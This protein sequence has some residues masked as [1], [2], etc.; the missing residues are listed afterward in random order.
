M[1]FR[2]SARRGRF[3][4]PNIGDAGIQALQKQQSD[5]IKFLDL[6]RRQNLARGEKHIANLKGVANTESENARIIQNVENDIYKTKVD[7]IN[8]AG[9]RDVQ[10]LRDEAKMFEASSKFW[11]DFSGAGARALGTA[12]QGLYDMAEF[13]QGRR[14][15]ENARD[16][17]TLRQFASATE[18]LYKIEDGKIVI[19][20]NRKDITGEEGRYLGKQRRSTNRYYAHL[21]L[22]DFEDNKADYYR[23][24]SDAFDRFLDQQEEAGNPVSAKQLAPE[25]YEAWATHVLEQKGV[26]PSLKKSQEFIDDFVVQGTQVSGVY[27]R[28][29]LYTE[30]QNAVKDDLKVLL[31]SNDENRSDD[32]SSLISS[33][34]E[35]YTKDDK[36]RVT[37]FIGNTAD[38]GVYVFTEVLAKH[39]T[40]T[41]DKMNAILDTQVP[42]E[43]ITYREK[44]KNRNIEELV[45]EA[46]IDNQKTITQ[47]NKALDLIDD[48][49]YKA[50]V[51]EEINS[52][53]IDASTKEGR[54]E[55]QR[56]YDEA[57][58]KGYNESTSYISELLVY[59]KESNVPLSIQTNLRLAAE[60]GDVEWFNSIYTNSLLSNKDRENYKFLSESVNYITDYKNQLEQPLNQELRNALGDQPSK[61]SFSKTLETAQ[62]MA[63]TQVL[64]EF[65][66]LTQ[67]NADKIEKG[68]VK[69]SQLFIEARN[70][71]AEEIRKGEGMWKVSGTI[72][73][74]LKLHFTAF[75][76]ESS[77]YDKINLSSRLTVDKSQDAY[78]NLVTYERKVDSD[79]QK[80]LRVPTPDAGRVISDSQ[81]MNVI[82]D[83][84]NG[85]EF[86]YT[87]NVLQVANHFGK[88]PREVMNDLL[89]NY[90][91]VSKLDDDNKA[92][93]YV[94][95]PPK[96]LEV[97]KEVEES[98]NIENDK[99]KPEDSRGKSNEFCSAKSLYNKVIKSG[100]DIPFTADQRIAFASDSEAINAALEADA[101]L[102]EGRDYTASSDGNHYMHITPTS[103]EGT[104]FMMQYYK[105]WGLEIELNG[106]LFDF[107]SC[108]FKRSL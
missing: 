30:T 9:T 25:F 73:E 64:N 86:T 99:K 89:A 38:A 58:L 92:H 52:G 16:D 56:K 75:E 107:T 14:Q 72:D 50:T 80:A 15:Y 26:S 49:G 34:R 70:K 54:Q 37:P 48:R 81:M 67:E 22:S 13:T 94:S 28:Q 79:T 35:S 60:K 83:I 61:T 91:D 55:L 108:T 69:V 106:S 19:E 43:N 90:T 33:V 40:M 93:A 31:S 71:V 6:S 66:T 45:E 42:N 41:R 39:P 59:D 36:G 76:A 51:E 85:Q 18:A 8:V 78:E 84:E 32:L 5:V 47:R 101:G 12:A 74:N 68:E 96:E 11:G 7:A 82:R 27:N 65:Y 53:K 17:G 102:I 3:N 57:K 104:Q 2:S 24:A 4:R 20:R 77:G 88:D 63:E 44:L 62:T 87:E 100:I 46:L 97:E 103:R 23:E 105:K 95:K 98:E 1:A 10:R 21:V 29:Q